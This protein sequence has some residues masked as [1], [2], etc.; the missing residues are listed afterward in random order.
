M[1]ITHGV[2]GKLKTLAVSSRTNFHLVQV[3]KR[4]A[5][6]KCLICWPYRG[7]SQADGAVSLA[8]HPEFP[9]GAPSGLC[10]L[11]ARV[12]S[13]AAR[14]RRP[15]SRAAGIGRMPGELV[16]DLSRAPAGDRTSSDGG[17]AGVDCGGGQA[18]LRCRIWVS[19]RSA[20]S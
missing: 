18:T 12:P 4:I 8:L 14:P 10:G 3:R 11:T 19:S 16:A 1:R 2:V 13:V 6:R 17:P 9:S 20:H 15:G 5:A 7:G